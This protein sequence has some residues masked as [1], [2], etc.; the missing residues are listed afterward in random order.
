MNGKLEQAGERWRL[1]FT[2][3]LAHPPEKV[4]RALTEHEHLQAWFPHTVVGEWTA[5]A[6]LRFQSKHGDFEG[7][8][9]ACQPPSLLEFRWGPDTIRLEVAPASGGDG[10][11]LTLIDTLQE[12]GKAARDGAGWHA[13][14]D[15]L[16]DELDGRAPAADS[17]AR[18]N[19]VHPG[20][21]EAFGPEA[22]TIG[23][24]EAVL[25]DGFDG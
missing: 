5:G 2:R 23:P 21:V 1:R 4:W 8:V 19:A 25:A 22:A 17:S 7:E 16:Q 6:P 12:L 13:C 15:A 11:T 18:W 14:L 24:P 9:L 10:C 3:E 20:Y